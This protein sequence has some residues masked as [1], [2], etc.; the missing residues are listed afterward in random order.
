M[1]PEAA[2]QEEMRI[3]RVGFLWNVA[4]TGL[5][6]V[7]GV[8]G[9]SIS[10]IA[11]AAHSVSDMLSDGVTMLT[12]KHAS[13]PADV[14][15]PYGHGRI[16]DM[17]TLVVSGIVTLTGLGIGWHAI[18]SI[19][20]YHSAATVVTDALASNTG[21]AAPTAHSH[22]HSHGHGHGHG[23]GGIIE[24]VM[25]KLAGTD[26]WEP[27]ASHHGPPASIALAVALFA[28]G[29]KEWLFRATRAVAVRTQSRIVEINAWHHRSDAASSMVAVVG[30][31]GAM[32]KWPLLDPLAA[33]VVAAAITK[34]GVDM[35][36]QVL[37]DI[38]DRQMPPELYASLSR[39][40]AT[41]APQGVLAFHGLRGRRM[42][43]YMLVDV[44]IVVP[45]TFSVSA[46]HQAAEAV[47]TRVLASRNGISEVLVHVDVDGDERHVHTGLV[48]VG[49]VAV[50]ASAADAT[51]STPT[52][53]P[54]AAVTNANTNA[55][56][57]AH[58]H[59]A[60]NSVH[61]VHGDHDAGAPSSSVSSSSAATLS[62][63]TS[64]SASSNS[65]TAVSSPS[66]P[67]SLS[68]Q[69]HDHSHSA[70]SQPVS[71]CSHD[72]HLAHESADK[73][74]SCSSDRIMRSQF[75]IEK[76]VRR[77]I[78]AF[79]QQGD[80]QGPRFNVS[81][82]N[83]TCHY[84]AERLTVVVEVSLRPSPLSSSSSSS[85][86]SSSSSSETAPLTL[87]DV[88][89]VLQQLKATFKHDISDVD[90]ARVTLCVD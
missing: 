38:T 90:E 45:N 17:G 24:Y 35:G 79:P 52:V 18:D 65:S 15:H 6:F 75:E 86:P 26:H 67:S 7:A 82:R 68:G 80:V 55:N 59:A 9:G 10:L 76:D 69:C 31:A 4:L 44:S 87:A 89:R 58:A 20:D 16:E 81:F 23:G 70:P 33:L 2:Q 8:V 14:D 62:S 28:V 25:M 50:A 49:D 5:K 47:R 40:V 61:A 29:S 36:V 63:S 88:S 78:A 30:I 32:A 83:L 74:D 12:I 48:R 64:A 21:T 13:R 66:S 53:G 11:D 19:V 84:V 1:T 73:D 51:S 72:H 34:Q 27:A 77:V 57:H 54:A 42:G 85:L 60:E 3:T 37:H 39:A 71:E 56:A 22:G 43:R 46:A 41:C